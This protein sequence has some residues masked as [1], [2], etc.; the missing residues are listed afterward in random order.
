LSER[1]RW[2]GETVDQLA[3][4]PVI[5]FDDKAATMYEKLLLQKLRI[6]T[7]DLLIASIVLSKNAVLLT[8][9]NRDF[10]RVPSLRL[11][12]WTV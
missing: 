7:Q 8:R 6:G 1:D 11:D 3:R 9:N 10:S 2:L 5:Y 12:D 4:L